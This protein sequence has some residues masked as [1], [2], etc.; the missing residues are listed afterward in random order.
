MKHTNLVQSLNCLWYHHLFPLD[1]A[2]KTWNYWNHYLF[3]LDNWGKHRTSHF[4][5]QIHFQHLNDDNHYQTNSYT[6]C[7]EQHRSDRN[8][9]NLYTSHLS[10]ETLQLWRVKNYIQ[11]LNNLALLKSF[12]IWLEILPVYRGWVSNWRGERYKRKGHWN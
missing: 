12:S 2:Q 7:T 8:Y 9:H 6:N 4:A 1:R 11:H 10:T 3:W 5:I